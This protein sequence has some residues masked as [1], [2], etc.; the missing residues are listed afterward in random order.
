M[1]VLKANHHRAVE[2]AGVQGLVQ[3]PVD[4]DQTH[5]GFD[6]LRTLRIYRFAPPQ[7]I[8]GQAEED[9]VYIVV[10]TGT[11][12]LKVRSEHWSSNATEFVVTAANDR[13]HA[14][15]AAFL[16]PHAEYTLTPRTN[17]DVAYARAR[18]ATSREP[19]LF[20]AAPRLEE[21]GV[22][23]LLDESKHAERL[24][25][26]LLHVGV[27][28]RSSALTPIRESDPMGEALIHVRTAPAQSATQ[29]E[30]PGMPASML[31]SWDT[32]A[33]APG[34]RPTLRV[35]PGSSATGLVVA[36]R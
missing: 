23:V 19:G 18:P 32:I 9:E 11:V 36:A 3:R 15:C 2:L 4:I 33:A 14:A 22:C 24:R 25:I 31:E 6:T 29:L 10:L 7:V 26:R 20:A 21:D 5:T 13:S 1:V 28:G 16:P 34:E 12:D 17:S 35:A 30:A 8:V 27:G